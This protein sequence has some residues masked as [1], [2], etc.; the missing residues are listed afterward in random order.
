M[1]SERPKP[2][3]RLCGKPMLAYVLESLATCHAERAAIVIGH[4]GEWVH[5]KIAERTS[6]W[7]SS[8]WSRPCSGAPA[9]LPLIGLSGLPDDLTD[10]GDVIVLPGD[11]PLLTAAT[12]G[13][14]VEQHRATDVAATVLTAVLDDATGYGRVVRGRNGRV[15]R[16]VEHGDAS[17]RRA[18]DPRGQHVDLLLQ[19]LAPGA[20]AATAEPRQRAGRVLPHRRHRRAGRGRPLGDTVWRRR[21]RR[22]RA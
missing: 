17:A 16:I 10:E 15:T 9:T 8:S 5:K 19:A 11:T 4:K 3:H 13:R 12:I 1:K 14:L 18:G 22:R 20:G 21:R 6:A 7:R 2:L